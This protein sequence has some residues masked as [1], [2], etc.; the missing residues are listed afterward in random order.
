MSLFPVYCLFLWISEKGTRDKTEENN[1]KLW[2]IAEKNWE[3]KIQSIKT[4]SFKYKALSN[5]QWF[6]VQS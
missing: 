3:A 2:V 5:N 4:Q 6:L 1:D